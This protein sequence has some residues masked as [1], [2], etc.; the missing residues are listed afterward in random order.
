MVILLLIY[1][2]QCNHTLLHLSDFQIT[3]LS[4]YFVSVSR[5]LLSKICELWL[6]LQSDE[7]LD[8]LVSQV[9]VNLLE[10]LLHRSLLAASLVI[11]KKCNNALEDVHNM[12]VNKMSFNQFILNWRSANCYSVSYCKTG[13]P[14]LCPKFIHARLPWFDAWITR[15]GVQLSKHYLT[16][17]SA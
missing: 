11:P 10:Q 6:Y 17:S 7:S 4:R 13:D 8:H 16:T 2:M 9:L 5:F 14:D 12:G 3:A 1:A 15:L